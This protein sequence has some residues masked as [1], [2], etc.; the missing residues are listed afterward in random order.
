[1]QH[2]YE[3]FAAGQLLTVFS[4]TNYCNQHDN[5]GAMIVLVKDFSSGEVVEHAQVIK[6]GIAATSEK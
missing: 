1:M 6:S 4:A 2:G 3:Y 5:D